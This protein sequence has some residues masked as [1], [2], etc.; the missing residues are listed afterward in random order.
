MPAQY[1]LSCNCLYSP[2]ALPVG[3]AQGHIQG[4]ADL[5]YRRARPLGYAMGSLLPSL[6][7]SR[8]GGGRLRPARRGH[9]RHRGPARDAGAPHD[10][11]SAAG[12]RVHPG[13]RPRR[14]RA[15][16]ARGRRE[17]R[18]SQADGGR[19]VDFRYADHGCGPDL[20]VHCRGGVAGAR[21][22]GLR[23]ARGPAAREGGTA[24]SR[25]HSCSRSRGRFSCCP[26]SRS[27][28]SSCSGDSSRS[29]CRTRS[30][31]AA[32][33]RAPSSSGARS[34]SRDGS[35]PRARDWS[36][37]PVRGRSG[38]AGRSR[39]HDALRVRAR[40]VGPRGPVPRRRDVERRRAHLVP[41]VGGGTV[42]CLRRRARLWRRTRRVRARRGRPVRGAQGA[43]GTARCGWVGRRCAGDCGPSGTRASI[44]A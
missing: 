33:S 13:I 12:G 27:R 19:R 21:P 41:V 4:C 7:V 38:V 15:L 5:Q 10:G 39:R 16:G 26:R 34:S 11:I 43:G 9:R 1:A 35:G 22:D 30:S 29:S 24:R 28:A 3:R 31:S 32:C 20:R 37:S 44:A 2:I 18:P 6:P 42:G 8:R 40:R 36:G 17:H 25:S 14:P 23:P